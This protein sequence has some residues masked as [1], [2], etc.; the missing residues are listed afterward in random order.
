[1]I[2]CARAVRCI[3]KKQIPAAECSEAGDS[4]AADYMA[5]S[6]DSTEAPRVAASLVAESAVAA[7]ANCVLRLTR[8]EPLLLLAQICSFS[9]ARHKKIPRAWWWPEGRSPR[10]TILCYLTGRNRCTRSPAN[11]SPV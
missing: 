9:C 1:M 4:R 3:R 6:A 11:T 5:R 10:N 2:E 8:L 7:A